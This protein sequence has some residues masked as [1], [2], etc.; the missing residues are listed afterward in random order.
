LPDRP[1]LDAKGKPLDK[2]GKRAK[3][4]P[5]IHWIANEGIRGTTLLEICQKELKLRKDRSPALTQAGAGSGG[6]FFGLDGGSGGGNTI[7]V[8]ATLGV[9]GWLESTRAR[10]FPPAVLSNLVVSDSK[11]ADPVSGIPLL[12]TK[13]EKA[14]LPLLDRLRLRLPNLR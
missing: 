9:I 10:G 4:D 2:D 6:G 7:T 8:P 12:E 3:K 11:L 1:S 5:D 13:R 14:V